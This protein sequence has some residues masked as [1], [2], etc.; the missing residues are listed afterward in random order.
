MIFGLQLSSGRHIGFW[1]LKRERIVIPRSNFLLK[2]AGG[3]TA[4]LS[5]RLVVRCTSLVHLEGWPLCRRAEFRIVLLMH[6]SKLILMPS[7][8]VSKIVAAGSLQITG[9]THKK[10]QC[11]KCIQW[12]HRRDGLSILQQVL[13]LKLLTYLLHGAE[14]FL[15][16]QLVLQ[17]VKKFPAFLEPEGSS[18]YPQAPATCPYPEPTPS[19]PHN[20]LPLH[21]DPA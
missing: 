13:L 9:Y 2:R 12:I 14:S 1:P 20:S 10:G 16:S 3:Y 8:C 11:A 15:R 21:E 7:R 18:P 17:L 19:S 5:D 6:K 4:P